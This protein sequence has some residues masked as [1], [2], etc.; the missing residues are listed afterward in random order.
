MYCVTLTF[1]VWIQ[2]K[3]TAHCLNEDNI[4]TKLERGHEML[5]TDRLTK[6]NPIMPYRIRGGG[7]IKLAV[8]PLIE[9]FAFEKQRK[10][11]NKYS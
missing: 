6:C 2:V 7:L 8:Q 3:V 11:N 10:L 9:G 5:R 1:E 4:C